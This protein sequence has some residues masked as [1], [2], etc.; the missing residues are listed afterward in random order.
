MKAVIGTEDDVIGLGLTGI[1]QRRILPMQA[2]ITSIRDA[3]NDLDE[4]TT[5]VYINEALLTTL[6]YHAE[7]HQ[8]SHE[9]IMIPDTEKTPN[10][11]EIERMAKET[12]G[13][14]I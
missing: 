3:A 13:I 7:P 14:S 6:R 10:I 8:H 2:D 1:Q 5:T 9:Y 12:L 11:D 4:D